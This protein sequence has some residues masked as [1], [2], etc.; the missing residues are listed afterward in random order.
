MS[1]KN[2]DRQ[3]KEL[4]DSR[5]SLQDRLSDREKTIALIKLQFLPGI[6]LN[7]LTVA[8]KQAELEA[9]IADSPEL[10]K[11]P[12]TLTLHGIKVGF[13]KAKGTLK[14]KSAA[15]VLKLIKKHFKGKADTLIKTTEKPNK[16]ALINLDV[17]DLKKL[18]VTVTRTGDEVVVKS[19]ESDIDKFIDA[20]LKEK[21]DAA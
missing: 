10:F 8:K 21:E 15:Q 9:M 14:W 18:G 17:K 5:R 3:A 20:L 2:I 1:L 12:R 7:A 16:A 11:R 6:K 4:A 19:T 13:K